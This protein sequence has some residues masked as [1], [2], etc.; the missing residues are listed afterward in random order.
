MNDSQSFFNINE[1]FSD[2]GGG[3]GGG[4]GGG[5]GGDVDDETVCADEQ[6]E[7]LRS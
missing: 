7:A 5:G 1:L 3:G 4:N 2:N 6:Y